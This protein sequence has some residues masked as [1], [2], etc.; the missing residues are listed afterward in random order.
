MLGTITL[1][2]AVVVQIGYTIYCIYKNEAQ[3]KIKNILRICAF[4]LSLLLLILGIYQWT[5]C[6]I[7]LLLLLALFAVIGI[8]YFVRKPVCTKSFR[9]Y[10]LI[11][12]SVASV[13]ILTLCISPSIIFP[14]KGTFNF[15]AITVKAYDCNRV[16]G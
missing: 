10:K 4:I 8:I 5:F 16:K 12:S 7:P 6:W 14:T 11:C 3:P 15:K 2:F 13:L 9:R 1:L